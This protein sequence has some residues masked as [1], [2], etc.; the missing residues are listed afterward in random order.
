MRAVTLASLY[1]FLYPLL[2]EYWSFRMPGLPILTISRVLLL[3]IFFTVTIHFISNSLHLKKS[4]TALKHDKFIKIICLFFTWRALSAITSINPLASFYG[5]L[6]D[7]ALLL[8]VYI[9]FSTLVQ[10]RR[11]AITVAKSL[12]ASGFV[13]SI[14]ALIEYNVGYNLIAGLTPDWV[15]LEPW[16]EAALSDK[17]RD[18]YR[19]QSTFTNPLVLAQFCVFCLPLGLYFFRGANSIFEKTTHLLII[20]TISGALL[21]TGSRFGIL[22]LGLWIIFEIYRS[23]IYK[24]RSVVRSVLTFAVLISVTLAAFFAV[25]KKIQ[26]ES[27]EEKLSTLARVVQF[28]KSIDAVY[29]NPILGAGLKMAP[30]VVGHYTASGDK[31]VDSYL[32]SIVVETGIPGLLLSLTLLYAV[33]IKT[34]GNSS[35]Y[36]LEAHF[37]VCIAHLCL[38]A[39]VLSI[40]EIYTLL[41]GIIGTYSAL[42]RMNESKRLYSNDTN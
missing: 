11:D 21:S 31:S 8:A 1:I 36:S 26:T 20:M 27:A 29:E 30:E 23:G 22:I 33:L 5:V 12:Y 34:H 13:V 2:P 18:T 3:L 16:V 35:K 40:M 32:L 9:L 6:N 14:L 7:I 28:Q 25:T 24:S 19:A 4:L 15:T 10:S 42:V 39:L 38:F 41:F 17:T 37:K